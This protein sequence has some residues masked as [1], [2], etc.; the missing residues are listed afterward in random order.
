MSAT[1]E[2]YEERALLV[3]EVE[4]HFLRKHPHRL[5]LS[6]KERG[7]IE[8]WLNRGIPVSVIC[9]GI[10]RALRSVPHGQRVRN[11][12]Y[13]EPAIVALWRTRGPTE[14]DSPSPVSDPVQE[15]ELSW[16]EGLRRW[17]E[18]T[19]NALAGS[20]ELNDS[21]RADLLEALDRLL[22]EPLALAERGEETDLKRLGESLEAAA[23]ALGRALE[24]ALEEKSRREAEQ[25]VAR[26]LRRSGSAM[27]A[28]VREETRRKML[29]LE[30]LRR[31]GIEQLSLYG[32]L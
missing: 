15:A 17:Q 5:M 13:C 4:L 29:T 22:G 32:L 16:A 23:A 1:V 25:A 9:R 18:M 7:R 2:R 30:L 19:R 12:A 31:L 6:P 20:P 28:K 10:E 3:A 27:S 14:R 21:A 11:V 24:G 8:E 26:R